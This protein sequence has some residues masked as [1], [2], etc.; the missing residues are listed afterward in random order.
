MLNSSKQIESACGRYTSSPTKTAL[1]L[2][3]LYLTDSAN[4][5]SAAVIK[6]Y[7][8][9][10]NTY[11]SDM[12]QIESEDAGCLASVLTQ[13]LAE[14][15]H[16]LGDVAV[17]DVAAGT[18]LVG[19]KLHEDGYRYITALDISK[20]MLDKAEN[21]GVYKHFILSDFV[22]VA[23]DV[24]AR[25]FYAVVMRGGF[26]AGHLPLASLEK[27]AACCKKGGLVINYMVLEFAQV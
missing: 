4:I 6:F 8:S 24:P 17:L 12:I 26:A 9:W 25:S 16:Y 21:K 7:E 3:P 23:K 10:A 15:D 19:E 2:T 11:D 5:G 13:W 18:G 14:D 1:N 20:E 27:M 22:D